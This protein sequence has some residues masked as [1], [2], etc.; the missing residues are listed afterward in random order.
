MSAAVS[1]LPAP[2]PW[3]DLDEA[4]L[5]DC[6]LDLD[7]VGRDFDTAVNQW[8][9]GVSVQRRDGMWEATWQGSREAVTARERTI[10]DACWELRQKLAARV[11]EGW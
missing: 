2:S 10:T 11:K 9:G 5:E 6:M 7:Q 1:T 3:D 8:S 4:R